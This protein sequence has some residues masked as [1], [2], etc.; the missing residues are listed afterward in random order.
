MC[1]DGAVGFVKAECVEDEGM[2]EDGDVGGEDYDEVALVSVD[3]DVD[4]VWGE[5]GDGGGRDWCLGA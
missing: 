4:I 1:D 2:A 3:L 5:L